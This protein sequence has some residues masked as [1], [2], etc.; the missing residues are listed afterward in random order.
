M[1]SAFESL[2]P[3]ENE[4]HDVLGANV[5]DHSAHTVFDFL[6]KRSHLLDRPSSPNKGKGP[7]QTFY[8]LLAFGR[9]EPSVERFRDGK[10]VVVEHCTQYVHVC[11]KQI[12]LCRARRLT[13]CNH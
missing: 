10:N 5:S 11:S 13:A 1:A 12:F 4:R 8:E 9:L 2:E 6:R 3:I 7:V